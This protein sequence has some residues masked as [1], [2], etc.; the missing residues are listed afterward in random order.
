MR[1][2][3]HPLHAYPQSH[4]PARSVSNWTLDNT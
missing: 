4:V 3:N 1:D 2:A